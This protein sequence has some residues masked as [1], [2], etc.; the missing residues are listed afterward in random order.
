MALSNSP[1]GLAAYILE[2]FSTWTN[3]ENRAAKDGNLTKKYT[4]DELLD[5]IMVYW[6][7]GTVT[8]SMRFYSENNIFSAPLDTVG[9]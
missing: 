5:N 8:A 7:S 3:L 1:L 6:L 4:L 2:K 9:K